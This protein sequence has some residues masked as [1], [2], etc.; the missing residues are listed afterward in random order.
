MDQNQK[1]VKS[2]AP[3][4]RAPENQGEIG[5]SRNTFDRL[6]IHTYLRS[7]SSYLECN[8]T[9]VKSKITVTII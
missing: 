6:G 2:R 7:I 4:T 8:V 9:F 1:L 3:S 5:V